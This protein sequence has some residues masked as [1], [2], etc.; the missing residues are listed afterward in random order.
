M[1]ETLFEATASGLFS[2]N[3]LNLRCAI[4]KGGIC[5]PDQKREG[6]GR[7]PLGIWPMRRVFYRA[8]R[9]ARPQT[10]LPCVALRP[11]DGWCD[12]ADHRLYNRLITRPFAASHEQLWRD[13]H[14]Y[15]IIVELGYND[16]PVRA[17]RGSAIFLHL[18]KPDY[19]PTEGCVAI[20]QDDMLKVLKQAG[21]GSHL[22]ITN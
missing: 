14:V 15:D 13:D 7:S 1:R 12:A 5:Q 20:A 4:G 2:G 8:D 18:A 17:G 3:G 16:D 21:P 22:K 9:L 19:S 10:G 11:H 6:D